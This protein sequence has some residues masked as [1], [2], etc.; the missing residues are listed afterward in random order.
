[1][2][3]SWTELADEDEINFWPVY[4]DLAMVVVIIMLLFLMA[5]F[6]INTKMV[7]GG[8]LAVIKNQNNVLKELT[9]RDST[10][11]EKFRKGIAAV[12]KDGNLQLITFNSDIIFQLNQS[13]WSQLSNVG[14]NLLLDF[15]EVIHKNE[16]KITRIQIEGHAS[17]EN[18][19]HN[20]NFKNETDYNNFNWKLSSQRAFAVCR[21]FIQKGVNPAKLSFAGRGHY[22]PLNAKED[23][24]SSK[25]PNVNRRINVLLFY[26]GQFE[27]NSPLLR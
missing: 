27:G 19:A 21:A 3:D 12:K 14:R 26:S 24:K 16:D 6:V 1:M 7:G 17:W 23:Y 15:G 5:Q 18:W 2:Q 8:S 20:P 13:S 22:V 11:K 4:S 25:T 10:G 9:V